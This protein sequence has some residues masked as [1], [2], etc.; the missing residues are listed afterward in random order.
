M[1]LLSQSGITVWSATYDA[2]GRATVDPASTITNNLRYP[3]QYEDEET[4]MHY[5]WNR[6]YDSGTGRYVTWDPIGLNGGIN[7][8]TYVEGSP[9]RFVDPKGLANS[10]RWPHPK[11]PAP[12]SGPR[13]PGSSCGPEGDPNN[14]PNEFSG[15]SIEGACQNHDKC[16]ADCS[17]SKSQCDTQFYHDIRRACFNDGSAVACNLASLGYYAA[18]ALKGRDAFD[19]ARENCDTC[20]SKQH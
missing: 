3:G 6:Y 4:G 16:Y 2:F 20:S 7:T 19:K 10:G 5:N 12:K 1:K 14:F 11:K 9:V 13:F 15:Q 17:K 18:V 8:Y